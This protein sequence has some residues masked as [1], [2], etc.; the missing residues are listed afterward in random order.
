MRY[1][2]L[3]SDT[4]VRDNEYTEQQ[5]HTE[6]V[7]SYRNNSQQTTTHTREQVELEYSKQQRHSKSKLHTHINI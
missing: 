2:D 6:N 3:K 4:E 7:N 1:S 5:E